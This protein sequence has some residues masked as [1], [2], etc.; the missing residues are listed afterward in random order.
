MTIKILCDCGTKFAFDIEPIGGKMHAAVNCP[1]C[2]KDATEQANEI[3]AKQLGMGTQPAVPSASAPMAAVASGGPMKVAP[4][5]HGAG[6][7]R[8]AGAAP[9]APPP[10]PTF[11]PPGE[12]P[13][14]PPAFEMCAKHSQSPGAA[15]CVVCQKPICLDCMTLFGYGCSAYCRGLASRKNIQ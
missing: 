15:N 2:S 6:A 12:A 5:A 7:I 3:I 8:V 10:E 11:A 13:L 1:S 4:P 9:T 14:A